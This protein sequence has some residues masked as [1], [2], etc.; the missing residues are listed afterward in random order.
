MKKLYC[1]S[2]ILFLAGCEFHG[3]EC[4]SSPTE[5]AAVSDSV[6]VS[7][8][9]SEASPDANP[10][11]T[12]SG[13]SDSGSVPEDAGMPYCPIPRGGNTAGTLTN[14]AQGMTTLSDSMERGDCYR[15]SNLAVDG[16]VCGSDTSVCD[17]NRYFQSTPTNFPWWEV[18]LQTPVR[19]ESIVIHGYQW[20]T[21]DDVY[22]S[23]ADC[24]HDTLSAMHLSELQNYPNSNTF[25]VHTV[26]RYVRIYR[27]PSQAQD[28]SNPANCSLSFCEIQILSQL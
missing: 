6:N 14:V 27:V 19:I 25:D 17:E 3:S 4:D 23:F 11:V 22:I 10:I 20:G 8:A 15:P 28:C 2:M 9:G 7:D 16:N 18:D 5:D 12:D 13:P 1:I 26:A 21:A 24:H